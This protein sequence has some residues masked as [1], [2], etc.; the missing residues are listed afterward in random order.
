[1]TAG[2]L[3]SPISWE[4]FVVPEGGVLSCAISADNWIEDN[5]SWTG[6]DDW[7]VPETLFAE[8]TMLARADVV[9][10][11][12]PVETTDPE[13]GLLENFFLTRPGD[14]LHQPFALYDVDLSAYAGQE[15]RIRFLEADTVWFL[16]MGVDACTLSS[17][18]L[19]GDDE[20]EVSSDGRDSVSAINS[21]GDRL[22]VWRR[23]DDAAEGL[24]GKASS[25]GAFGQLF[26]E[27]DNPKGSEF[28]V[29]TG[30]VQG[31]PSVTATGDDFFVGW[32]ETGSLKGKFFDETGAS[33]GPAIEVE[34]GG[35]LGE[36]QVAASREGFAMVWQKGGMLEATDGI[37][38]KF[39]D[40]SGQPA[41]EAKRLDPGTGLDPQK[42]AAGADGEGDVFVVWQE[43]PG[44]LEASGGI[45]ARFFD[46]E[47]KAKGGGTQLDDGEAAEPAA[48]VNSGG[49]S[50]AAW[51]KTSATEANGSDVFAQLLDPN[52]TKKGP[53]IQVNREA[54][55]TH[56]NPAPSDGH[57]HPGAGI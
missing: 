22:V 33:Q 24:V 47:G 35:G 54:S 43:T 6:P 48:S 55:G 1:M 21:R 34:S 13:F 39:F 28:E 5:D 30:D 52:G 17:R 56:G 19:V 40:K 16:N 45:F 7:L 8:H 41:G 25:G 15:V 27:N 3:P 4:D 2:I 26:D 18:G 10:S 53:V 12:A 42:P 29:A 20:R 57:S 9:D 14:P 32:P 31:S 44:A 37:F 50:V 46:K 38:G 11:A 36:P 49:Q 23:L 51:Q